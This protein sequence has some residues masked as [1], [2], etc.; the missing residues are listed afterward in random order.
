MSYKEV[1]KQFTTVECQIQK[2]NSGQIII[3]FKKWTKNY[4]NVAH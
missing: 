1:K 3:I 2:V 4:D